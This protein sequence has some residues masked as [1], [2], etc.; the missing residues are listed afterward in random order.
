MNLEGI[1]ALIEA[2]APRYGGDGND[3]IMGRSDGDLIYAGAGNNNVTV[4]LKHYPKFTT[5]V[6]GTGHD[7]LHTFGSYGSV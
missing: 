3:S 1:A 4:D 6:G 2:A 7:D 5:T